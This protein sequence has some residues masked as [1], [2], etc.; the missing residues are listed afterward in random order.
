MLRL[1]RFCRLQVTSCITS[2]FLPLLMLT[3]L[4]SNKPQPLPGNLHHCRVCLWKWKAKVGGD[5]SPG[6]HAT[7]S[8]AELR[9]LLGFM[10]TRVR[11]SFQLCTESENPTFHQRGTN[12]TNE[13]N[14]WEDVQPPILIS[15]RSRFDQTSAPLLRA[16]T[17]DWY[18]S[19]RHTPLNKARERVQPKPEVRPV[20]GRPGRRVGPGSELLLLCSGVTCSFIIKKKNPSHQDYWLKRQDN[21]THGKR[22]RI[23]M[24]WKWGYCILK[25]NMCFSWVVDSC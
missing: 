6:R 1:F 23:G 21:Q 4:S 13:R 18:R 14:I 17:V 12:Q 20:C 25:S 8:A 16:Q 19:S 24:E 5:Q 15:M 7:R 11:G 10:C 3:P 9:I 22:S 2:T